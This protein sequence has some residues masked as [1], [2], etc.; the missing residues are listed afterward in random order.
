MP[1]LAEVEYYRKQWSPAL[2][3]RVEAVHLHADKRIFRGVD[4]EAM[5]GLL[6][7]K[8]FTASEAHGKQMC[9][10]FASSHWLGLHLGMTGKLQLLPTWQNPEKHDHL[11][12]RMETEQTLVFS[13]PRM[14][15]RILYTETDSEPSWW[16]GRPPNILSD[17]FTLERMQAFLDRRPKSPIKAVLLMQEIFPGIGNWMADEILWRSRI[18]PDKPCSAVGPRKR[19]ALFDKVREVSADAMRVIGSDWGDPP[20]DWL[21]NHRWRDGGQCPQTGRPL[22]RA[23]IA[24]RTTCW[25]PAWQR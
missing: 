4:T 22:R 23:Q 11:V 3:Q 12:I 25:S 9:F 2:H 5:E 8:V 24:G 6:I 14:F 15:G 21:F 10:R 19:R 18:R 13:D 20:N 16:A 17:E 1:E 7:G